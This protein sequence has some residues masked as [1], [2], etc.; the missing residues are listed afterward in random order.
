[1]TQRP[2]LEPIRIYTGLESANSLQ[3]QANLALEDLKRAGGLKRKAIIVYTPSTN[4]LVDPTASEAAEYVMGG[5][6]TSVSMQYTVLPS[7]L[8]IML[9][10]STSLDSGTILFQT[11]RNAPT[12]CPSA[13]DQSCTSTV[14]ASGAFGSQAPFTNLGI[15]GL[16]N[17]AD[18]ALWAGLQPIAPTGSR[19]V[20]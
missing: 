15:E 7:F 12:S 5:D 17:Q 20:P 14:K 13:P 11:V 8:S 1:M 9:S 3:D 6:V 2:A 18:G 4:G 10:Q 19:S 16:T